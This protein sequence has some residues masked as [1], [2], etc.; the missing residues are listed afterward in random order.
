MTVRLLL[1]DAVLSLHVGVICFV[2][3]GL[4]A[5]WWGAWSRHPWARKPGLRV[6]HSATIGYVIMETWAGIACPLT[7]LEARLRGPRSGLAEGFIPYWLHRLLFY[8]LPLRD[9]QV[10]YTVFGA[11]VVLTWVLLPPRWRRG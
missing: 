2:V 1:A 3:L 8:D 4:P 6:L 11:A 10:A 5:I 7:V 9:F